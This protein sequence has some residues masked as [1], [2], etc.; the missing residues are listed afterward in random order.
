MARQFNAMTLADATNWARYEKLNNY[1]TP[2]L[3]V[4]LSSEIE[5]H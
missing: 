5:C 2:V 3:P 4:Q 1:Y